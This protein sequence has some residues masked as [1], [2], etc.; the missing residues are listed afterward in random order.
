ML[1][2]FV[3]ILSWLLQTAIDSTEQDL[4]DALVDLLL[5]VLRKVVQSTQN[6]ADDELYDVV[7]KA[8][9]RRR[10]GGFGA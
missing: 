7:Y 1:H 10:V 3:P 8:V 2:L 9:K 5:T 6:D 4:G